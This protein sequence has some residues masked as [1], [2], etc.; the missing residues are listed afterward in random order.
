[1]SKQRESGQWNAVR[2]A[3]S[4]L[5]YMLKYVG[6]KMG[7]ITNWLFP[8]FVS[9]LALTFEFY[10]NCLCKDL[11]YTCIY[12]LLIM[13]CRC[14]AEQQRWAQGKLIFFFYFNCI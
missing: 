13:G 5:L 3:S 9:Y 10:Y 4:G 1:M 6:R 8:N 2:P 14:D 11:I 7:A 12:L